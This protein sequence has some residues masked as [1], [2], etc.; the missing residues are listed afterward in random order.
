MEYL[1]EGDMMTLLM[2]RDTVTEDE[3]GFY[4]PEIV[5]V[6]EAIQK[7]NYIHR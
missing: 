6:T 7:H 3:A 5:L 4:V 1:S 2:R